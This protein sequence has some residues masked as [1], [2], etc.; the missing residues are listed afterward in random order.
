MDSSAQIKELMIRSGI[1]IDMMETASA[2]NRSSYGS[3]LPEH[4]PRST[5]LDG[6]IQ[7][8]KANGTGREDDRAGLMRH[9]NL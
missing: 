1:S 8:K 9:S 3:L 4:V 5:S 6:G 7:L 2:N